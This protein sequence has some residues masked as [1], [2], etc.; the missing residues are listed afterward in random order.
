MILSTVSR[1]ILLGPFLAT[2][3]AVVLL[4]NDPIMSGRLIWSFRLLKHQNLSTGDD[5]IHQGSIATA[6]SHIRGVIDPFLATREVVA[7]LT[8]DPIM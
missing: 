5:F 8:N 3:E 7:P 6:R 2:R 1:I 4:E